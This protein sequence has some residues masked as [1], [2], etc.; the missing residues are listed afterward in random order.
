MAFLEPIVSPL[1]V[2][3]VGTHEITLK[4]GFVDWL[5]I[6]VSLVTLVYLIK[7]TKHTKDILTQSIESRRDSFVFYPSMKWIRWYKDGLLRVDFDSFV[8]DSNTQQAITR[9]IHLKV[10]DT[11]YFRELINTSSPQNGNYSVYN[12]PLG[13]AIN[14]SLQKLDVNTDDNKLSILL[15]DF[16]GRLHNVELYFCCKEKINCLLSSEV[17]FE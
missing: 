14:I 3:I 17:T 8:N 4:T 12:S 2:D 6:A 7:Y 1:L 13:M 16:F 5:T 10:N 9:I 11:P 15:Q